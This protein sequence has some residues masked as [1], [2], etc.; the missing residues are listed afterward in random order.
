MG[1]P[2][3]WVNGVWCAKLLPISV[4]P[5]SAP[6]GRRAGRVQMAGS[7]SPEKRPASA[8]AV[9][10][11]VAFADN[12]SDQPA[13]L[14]LPWG[15]YPLPTSEL[16]GGLTASW[17]TGLFYRSGHL[18]LGSGIIVAR[19]VSITDVYESNGLVYRIKVA[20]GGPR[21]TLAEQNSDGSLMDLPPSFI[22]KLYDN[23][24]L[25][26]NAQR[27]LLFYTKLAKRCPIRVPR[28]FWAKTKPRCGAVSR[29]PPESWP[30][31]EDFLT[32]WCD[33][34]A[35]PIPWDQSISQS[36]SMS[37]TMSESTW[38]GSSA[39]WDPAGS[40]RLKPSLTVKYAKILRGAGIVSVSHLGRIA[41]MVTTLI[42]R[43]I[44]QS[45]VLKMVEERHNFE[46][47]M[48]TA[49][50]LLEDLGDT[51][52]SL[53]AD[54]LPLPTNMPGRGGMAAVEID[55]SPAT[56]LMSDALVLVEEMARLH[57]AWWQHPELTRGKHMSCLNPPDSTLGKLAISR[58]YNT[59]GCDWWDRLDDLWPAMCK[60]VHKFK[61]L[62]KR[63]QTADD[64]KR[65][66]SDRPLTL[67]HGDMHPANALVTTATDGSA[68]GIGGQGTA[69]I[70][71]WAEINVS[72]GAEEMAHFLLRSRFYDYDDS[73]GEGSGSPQGQ[74]AGAGSGSGALRRFKAK[75]VT[76]VLLERYYRTLTASGRGVP[77]S[78]Y[79][80]NLMLEHVSLGIMGS[81]AKLVTHLEKLRADHLEALAVPG[82]RDNDDV[83]VV[84]GSPRWVLEELKTRL[85]LLNLLQANCMGM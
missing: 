18:K 1:D 14:E 71:D 34:S 64:V 41:H 54:N 55:P 75:E 81:C 58:E 63:Y 84:F 11:R 45:H 47:R 59:N 33:F 73:A 17:L 57:A 7:V 22:L 85:S 43:G 62:K 61:R 48:V 27:E 16:P 67:L 2:G 23:D 21:K 32:R 30:S 68:T 31:I 38:G 13:P 65:Y 50:L 26:P 80:Y 20:Y 74:G 35:E 46:P 77:T 4:R 15:D 53:R 42:D 36:D 49:A 10:R 29:C 69:V 8:P 72:S 6:A 70:F 56:I 40:P 25:M 78:K 83:D 52:S 9:S 82:G 44:R 28:C 39:A 37:S 19:I 79:S 3:A 60:Y 66:Y 51:P 24:E 12:V 76:G 5:T